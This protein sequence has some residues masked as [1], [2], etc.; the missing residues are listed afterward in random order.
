MISW[1]IGAPL[2]LDSDDPER[3][4]MSNRSRFVQAALVAVLTAATALFTV[5]ASAPAH[6][7]PPDTSYW[8]DAHNTGYPHGLA[9]DTRTPVTLTTYTGPWTITT[10][11]TVIDGKLIP[12]RIDIRATGVVIK[13]SFIQVSDAQALNI[14][15][16]YH[17]TIMDTEIDGQCGDTTAGGISLVGDGSFTMIRVNAHGSGDIARA[18]WG[19]VA[20]VDSWLHDPCGTAEAEETQHNDVLQT[21]DGDCDVIA[22]GIHGRIPGTSDSVDGSFCIK[23]VHNRFENMQTQTSLMLFKADQGA[24]HDVMVYDNLLNGGGYS[25][26]WYD[27]NNPASFKARFGVFA[28]N[29]WLRGSG[30]AGVDTH[31]PWQNGGY[32]GPLAI[33]A[34]NL[35]VWFDNRWL[36]TG[37]PIQP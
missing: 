9:G 3:R 36:D 33:E 7:D 20:V 21:T 26:Y 25:V 22:D 11:N 2:K 10:P 31:G 27:N 12:D 18:N 8:P 6:A 35:P 30:Q 14:N 13:N 37:A 16:V 1:V 23:Y 5:V 15:D 32:Y 24:I 17:L 34:D 29:R 28:G 4:F 19:G